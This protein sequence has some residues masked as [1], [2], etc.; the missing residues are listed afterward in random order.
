MVLLVVG[1]VSEDG[2]VGKIRAVGQLELGLSFSES[3]LKF[4]YS[5]EL[6]QMSY[7]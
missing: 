7:F 6:K 2:L 5:L 3:C 1:V 4:Q